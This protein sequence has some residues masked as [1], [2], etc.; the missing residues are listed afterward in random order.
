MC[1]SITR[2]F[3]RE[4][5][6]PVAEVEYHK[7][8]RGRDLGEEDQSVRGDPGLGR[9]LELLWH[10]N[11]AHVPHLRD[12]AVLLGI[13]GVC[14]GHAVDEGVIDDDEKRDADA[15]YEPDVHHLEVGCLGK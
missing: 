9:A 5:I 11:G 15:E 6:T 12:A 3:I 13:A 14:V 2:Y 4:Y 1:I 7:N 8:Q 10:L